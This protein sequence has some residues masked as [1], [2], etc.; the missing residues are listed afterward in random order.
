[1]NPR[2]ASAVGITTGL[3]TASCVA[4]VLLGVIV[5]YILSGGLRPS[6]EAAY[7]APAGAT[8]VPP[9]APLAPARNSR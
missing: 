8:R 9:A 4:S 2:P 1:M 3:L 5:G 7:A 6:G